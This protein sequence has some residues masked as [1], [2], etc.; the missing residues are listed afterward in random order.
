MNK[1][2]FIKG[3]LILLAAG[4]LNRLLGFIPRIALPRIIG[5]EGV[6]IYQLGYPFF[7]VLVTIITGGIPLAIAKMVAEAEG[8]GK[9]DAS[10][11][12]LHVSLML[13]LIAGTLFTGL[14]LLLAPWVTG[15]LLPDE[16]V[17][18]T[19]ISM[20]PMLIII[21][22][23]SVYRGYF[24]GKQN[25]IP[26]A[27]SS[28]IETIVRIICML[29]FAHLLMPKGIAYG[30][31]GAMLGTAVGE[32]IGMIALLL[33][34]SGEGRRT[35]KLMP[36][37][38]Q[39]AITAPI[40]KETPPT[41][42]GILKRLFGIALPVTGGKMVGSF[43]YLLETI[44]TNRSLAMAGIATSVAT[45][46]YG[47]LQGMIIPLLLL[48]GALTVSLAISLVP[49]LSEAAARNDRATIHKRMNQSL[50]LALVSGA[51]FA[52][53][54]FVLAEPLCLLLYDNSE[55][56]DMLKIMAPFALFL[57]VQSPLQAALQALDRPGRA[58]LNTL[59]G[60]IIKMSLIV[61]LASNPA[62]GI[63]GAVIAIIVNSIAVTLLHGFSLSRLIGFRF[64]LLDY[65]KIGAVMI[66][67]GACVLY[68]YKHLPFASLPWLQFLASATVG[69]MVYLIVIFMTRL[70]T[71][72]DLERV[73]V[74]GSWFS[75][76]SRR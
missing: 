2:S 50:R 9:Q 65:V 68:G 72:R 47:A 63:K 58:L 53:L 76:L 10:K 15:V 62:F 71:P 3:T 21:A 16:R 22:V 14:S 11:Q 5:P 38:P 34:Y 35:N 48:P 29:W 60:A 44:L 25:M 27:S 64:R 70:V 52:I 57:Y 54:M 30:A 7:I 26:S 40:V 1:Q 24:Q 20:T 45:A 46:Q 37:S 75:R 51:P 41:N 17:Y 67:M 19:F 66:I 23:S 18:Q 74:V 42:K 31:A 73:P 8:A 59:V 36:R 39:E 49:S 32:L 13:T 56:S 4:I 55:I 61:Y 43:S 12:I 28:V 33:Q 69:V 6:G